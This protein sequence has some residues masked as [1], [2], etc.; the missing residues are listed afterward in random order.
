[1]H[2]Y[3]EFLYPLF[4]R[5][6]YLIKWFHCITNSNFVSKLILFEIHRN[7]PAFIYMDFSQYKC[8]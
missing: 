7:V 1:M 8:E 3:L 2:S 4:N 6:R 5:N